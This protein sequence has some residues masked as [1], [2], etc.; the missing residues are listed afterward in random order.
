MTKKTKCE[1]CGGRGL[2]KQ[3]VECKKCN[4]KGYKQKKYDR[5]ERLIKQTCLSCNGTGK[6]R[7]RCRLC[8]GYGWYKK[9]ETKVRIGRKR[10]Q[11]KMSKERTIQD[12]NNKELLEDLSYWI[13]QA[14]M[15]SPPFIDDVF[16]IIIKYTTELH[17]REDEKIEKFITFLKNL[18]FN[19]SNV[20][21]EKKVSIAII[22]KITELEKRSEK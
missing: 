12:L 16:A 8:S 6:I 20:T 2:L 14:Q 15:R 4:G 5:H 11:Q 9:K 19:L 1:R 13:Y 22:N 21:I 7:P 10:W 17:K 3:K 18:H